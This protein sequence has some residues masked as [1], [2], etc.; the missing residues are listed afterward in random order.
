MAQFAIAVGAAA[1]SAA[2]PGF[3]GILAGAAFSAIGGAVLASTQN[4]KGPRISDLKAPQAAYGSILPWIEGT[5]G[6]A[7]YYAWQS[8]K[9]SYKIKARSGGKGGPTSTSYGY[10]VDVLIIL[11]CNECAGIRRIKRNG[12]L[13]YSLAGDATDATVGAS[14]ATRNW[15]DIRFYSGAPDQLPD[16]TYEAAVGVGRCPANRGRA[17]ILIEALNLFGSDQMPILQIETFS[18]GTMGGI[19]ASDFLEDFSDYAIGLDPSPP[20]SAGSSGL[21]GVVALGDD[22]TYGIDGRNNFGAFGGGDQTNRNIT[23]IT[24]AAF[25]Q[26]DFRLTSLGDDDAISLRI[27]Q[28]SPAYSLEFLPRRE[29]SVDATGRPIL[30]YTGGSSYLGSTALLVDTWYRVEIVCASGSNAS[31]IAITLRDGTPVTSGN[32]TFPGGA[33]WVP[34]SL[35]VTEDDT[36]ASSVTSGTRYTNISISATSLTQRSVPDTIYLDEVTL[37]QHQRVGQTADDV[38]VTALAAIPVRGFAVTQLASVR[39][40]IEMLQYAYAT[41]VCESA[42]KIKYFLRGA[43]P[44][45]TIGYAELGASLGEAVDPLPL[46]RAQP[47][48]Q[49]AYALATFSNALDDY[50]EGTAQ[51]D[52]ILTAGNSPESTELPMVLSPSEAQRAVEIRALDITAGA[53]VGSGISLLRSWA[54]LEPCDVVNVI[55]PDG[56]MLRVNI[57][58]IEDAGLLRKI[59][60]RTEDASIVDVA[61]V[62]DETYVSSSV[63]LPTAVTMLR[64]IDGPI[65]RDADDDSGIYAAVAKTPVTS[66][67]PGATLYQGVA[68]AGYVEKAEFADRTYIGEAT[69]ALGDFSGIGFDEINSVT[70]SGLGELE[71]YTEDMVLLGTAPFLVIGDEWLHY[72]SATEV[73]IGVYTLSRLLRGRRGTE[74]AKATHAIGDDVT[75]IQ[76]EGVRR[77]PMT[78]SQVGVAFDYRAP[79][80]GTALDDAT[81]VSFTSMGLGQRPFAPVHLELSSPASPATLT[82]TRRT[83]LSCRLGGA[84]GTL[85]PLGEAS[86]SYVV[87]VTDAADAVLSTQTVSTNSASVTFSATNKLKVCQVS[88][89]YGRGSVASITV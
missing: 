17:S 58:R 23:G 63:V 18:H 28:T 60:I 7:G 12:K 25:I 19:E 53:I 10:E 22:Y 8:D 84:A 59:D 14:R 43:E 55:G 16:P 5:V 77:L 65:A 86:E 48:D 4:F 79:T 33:T 50:Q 72:L 24:A 21:M 42:G 83:R 75:L 67:W 70:V 29:L 32:F 3:G 45:A 20:W 51:S 56:S 27:S 34:G 11:S 1:I 62:T 82:W 37:R 69:T 44:V 68:D 46:V 89:T 54:R 74:A 41:D 61:A 88:E 78:T 9:R 85:I 87:E 26:F 73:S 40:V 39:S 6:V 35:V 71:N 52:R 76:P 2:I 49:P 81:L 15:A 47:M 80:D 57:R 64:L 31:S 66:E 38:D 30:Y 13:I 36:S